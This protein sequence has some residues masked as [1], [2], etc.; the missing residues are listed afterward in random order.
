MHI[1]LYDVYPLIDWLID[2]SISNWVRALRIP[3]HLGFKNG[4]LVP[5][6]LI[7]VQESP[8][9][10][11]K[12]QMALRRKLLMYSGSKKKE[13]RH[14]CLREA[15]A[16]HSQR[17]WTEV[18]Y[19]APHLLHKGLLVSWINWRY[20]LRVLCPVRCPI[21]TLDCVLLKEK[22]LFF[23][24]GLALEINSRASLWVHWYVRNWINTE[25]N[26]CQFLKR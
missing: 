7:P 8:F 5:H 20:L 3:M 9:P 6:N 10:S 18:S 1:G 21:T 23:A 26:Y 13:P 14:T 16:S 2:W 17:I 25:R 22:T 4:P 19:S 12:F 15:K 24:A 11:L